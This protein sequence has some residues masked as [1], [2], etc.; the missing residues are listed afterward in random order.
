MTEDSPFKSPEIV[1]EVHDSFDQL[2]QEIFALAKGL[3]WLEAGCAF[4]V[5]GLAVPPMLIM[6]AYEGHPEDLSPAMAMI[7]LFGGWILASLVTG[8]GVFLVLLR[9]GFHNRYLWLAVVAGTPWISIVGVILA[10]R[11]V[12]QELRGC[13]L[14][15]GWIGPSHKD[16][17]Q[18]LRHEDGSPVDPKTLGIK[19]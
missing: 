7:L 6:D 18:Q 17:V 16:I 19:R 11:L 4:Y 2:S 3:R 5:G 14:N 8:I 9:L 10:A 13:G 12:Q 15:F 1:D